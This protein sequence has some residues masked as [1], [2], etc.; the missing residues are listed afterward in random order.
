MSK[1]EKTALLVALLTCAE[2]AELLGVKE[3]TV[4]VWIARKKL[5]HTKLG[6]CVRIP[7]DAIEEFIRSGMVPAE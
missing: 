6:R 5:G 2:A 3:P 1:V 4:R 7:K